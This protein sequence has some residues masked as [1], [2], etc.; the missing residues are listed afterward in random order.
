MVTRTKTL[1][2]AVSASVLFILT[3]FP[4]FSEVQTTAEVR[5]Y[6]TIAMIDK[7]DVGYSAAGIGTLTFE[8]GNAENVK[9]EVAVEG[10]LSETPMLSLPRGYVKARFPWFRVTAGKAP[11]SW[12]VGFALNAGDVIFRQFDPA[13]QLSAENLRDMSALL[14]SMFIPVGYFSFAEICVLPPS[15]NV[16]ALAT[17]PDYSYPLISETQI[18][19]RFYL[20]A[21][22]AV[23][24]PGYLYDAG[25]DTHFPYISIQGHLGADLHLSGSL[26]IETRDPEGERIYKAFILSGGGTYVASLPGSGSLTFRLESLVYPAGKWKEDDSTSAARPVSAPYPEYGILLYPEINWSITESVSAFVRSLFCPVDMSAVTS[27]GGSWNIF[28][29]FDLLGF[30]SIEGGDETDTYAY[31][32]PGW[33]AFTLGMQYIY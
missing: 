30:I 2:Y 19:G 21:G 1:I 31:G 33:F 8:A 7:E 11:I 25:I 23:I 12:G 22:P 32:R 3:C 26:G 6:N 20:E 27:C 17:D 14:T 18:G 13:V 10:I 16:S 9:A 24:E 5:V 4:L 29:G 28:N 15:L